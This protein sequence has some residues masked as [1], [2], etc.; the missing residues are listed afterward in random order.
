[1]SATYG[2]VI[3]LVLLTPWLIALCVSDIR[4][5]KLPNVLTLGG[6][7]VALA[8]AAGM[9]GV[10]GLVDALFAA[11]CA[12]LFLIIGKFGSIL[13][14]LSMFYSPLNL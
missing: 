5:R 11:G 8:M 12:F 3:K 9:G 10:P 2:I 7:F 6:F 14:I 4:F 13:V 1:M